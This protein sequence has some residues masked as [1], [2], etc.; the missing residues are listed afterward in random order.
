MCAVAVTVTHRVA[1]DQAAVAVAPVALVVNVDKARAGRGENAVVRLRDGSGEL[2]ELADAGGVFDVQPRRVLGDGENAAVAGAFDA[3][4]HDLFFCVDGEDLLSHRGHDGR[5]LV[6]DAS[7]V[8]VDVLPAVIENGRVFF[9]IGL[10]CRL[11]EL[12]EEL[13]ERFFCKRLLVF[14]RHGLRFHLRDSGI[15]GLDLRLDGLHRFSCGGCVFRRLAPG[16]FLVSE[17]LVGLGPLLHDVVHDRLGK[18]VC[19]HPL[20]AHGG[21]RGLDVDRAPFFDEGVLGVAAEEVK[22]FKA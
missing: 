1:R 3:D 22:T 16:A 4:E 13:I 21:H 2:A 6:L 14:G 18:Q 9:H 12:P 19:C 10:H 5:A 17:T 7:L 20:V 11:I 8:D 15:D